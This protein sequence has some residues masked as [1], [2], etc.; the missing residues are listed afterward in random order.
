MLPWTQLQATLPRPASNA[1]PRE[2]APCWPR[3][4]PRVVAVLGQ[5]QL[6]SPS[7]TNFRSASQLGP[8]MALATT[9]L[10]PSGWA[11]FCCV[12]I[13]RSKLHAVQI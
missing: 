7:H 9:G 8:H 3:A 10:I 4:S 1:W 11:R 2:K 5:A 13:Q 12:A 6:A